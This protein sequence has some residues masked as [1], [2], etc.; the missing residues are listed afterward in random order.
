MNG[1]Q[2]IAD[3]RSNRPAP[4]LFSRIQEVVGHRPPF[5]VFCSLLAILLLAPRAEAALQQMQ[6]TFGGYTNRSEV[7]TNFPVLVVLSNNVGGTS[8]SPTS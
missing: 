5:T 7:L 4:G 1:Q 2:A 3:S 6:I 8:R